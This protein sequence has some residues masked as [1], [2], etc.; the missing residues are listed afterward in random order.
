MAEAI[1]IRHAYLPACTLG[2]LQ[3]H[4]MRVATIERPWIPV[5]EHRGGKVRESCV[6]DGKYQLIRHSSEKFPDV[7]ALINEELDVRYQPSSKAGRAAILIHKGNAVGDVIGC[8]AVGMAHGR[9]GGQPAVLRSA[10]AL[11]ELRAA[12]AGGIPALL[13]RATRGTSQGQPPYL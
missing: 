13:I 12:F 7:F 5:Q 2:W 10:E 4:G 11:D 8:I 9:L 3:Y 1:L 6:P